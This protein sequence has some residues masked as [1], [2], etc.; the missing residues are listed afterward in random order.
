MDEWVGGVGGWIDGWMGGCACAVGAC[1]RW[2]RVVWWCVGVVAWL[3]VGIT[4]WC[5][6]VEV[7][8]CGGVV[9]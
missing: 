7:W 1:L 5:G 6:G 4:E 9:V 3:C 2:V 8:W